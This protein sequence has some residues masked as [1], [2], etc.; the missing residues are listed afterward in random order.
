MLP[1]VKEGRNSLQTVKRINANWIDDKLRRN[2]LL[3]LVIEGKIGE[4]KK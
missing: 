3:K 4:G 2:F 1:R